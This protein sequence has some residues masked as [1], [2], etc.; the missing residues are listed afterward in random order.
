MI[1][2]QA[3][4]IYPVITCSQNSFLPPT[5]PSLSVFPLNVPYLPCDLSGVDHLLF[6]SKPS[7]PYGSDRYLR[8]PLLVA[9]LPV[10]SSVVI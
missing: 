9:C 6:C 2:P 5:I 3:T 10:L 4:R 7:Y 8:L 1:L